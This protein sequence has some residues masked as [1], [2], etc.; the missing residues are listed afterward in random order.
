MA[1]S[2]TYEIRAGEIILPETQ[3]FDKRSVGKVTDE[4]RD[5]VLSA[6]RQ[7][8]SD[9]SV[10][11]DKLQ[12]EFETG[13]D[14]IQ[15]A[16]KVGPLKKEICKAKAIGPF[17][18]MLTTLDQLEKQARNKVD[19]V[20]VQK[21][22]ILKDLEAV[23]IKTGIGEKA[24]EPKQEAPSEESKEEIKSEAKELGIKEWNANTKKVISL[25]KEFKV[26]PTVPDPK[27]EKF[28]KKLN[29][30]VNSF[31]NEKQKNYD[32]FEKELLNNLSIK[33]DIC[34]QAER[35]KD[36]KEWRKT[37]DTFK[38]I[39]EEWFGVG[40]VPRKR[41]NELWKRFND[42]K[43]VFFK[44]RKAFYDTLIKD[45]EVNLKKKEEIIVRAEALQDSTQWNKTSEQMEQLMTE[46]KAAGPVGKKKGDEIWAKFRAAR[47][48]FFT[49][50]KAHFET[51]RASFKE[52]LDKKTA[53]A[54]RAE[55]IKDS[56]EWDKTTTELLDMMAKWKVSGFAPKK[57]SDEL[58][59]SLVLTLDLGS[60]F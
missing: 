42:A 60:Y 18:Q 44:N 43:D 1:S 58:W 15:L 47:D 34:D 10:Q 41:Y 3:W 20:L 40:P 35:L 29:K 50:K 8:F 57:K 32:D 59:E 52:A 33:L 45:F 54:A 5:E 36:S 31:F 9:L 30:Q 12:F 27:D 6:L 23:L 37:T 48:K 51:R 2:Y 21:E 49:A 55:E 39:T 25:Q 26:L 19:S 7:T 11:V 14:L 28:R 17:D 13:Q 38:K 24:I 46:W 53:L 4:T 16:G 22:R 56:E